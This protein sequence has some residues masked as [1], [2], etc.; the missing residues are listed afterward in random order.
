[1]GNTDIESL[2]LVLEINDTEIQ[3]G[4]YELMMYKP[5]QILQ[6][7]M[8][9]ISLNDGD[10]I[11]IGTPEGLGVVNVGGRFRS[12]IK[13]SDEVLVRKDWVAQ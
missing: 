3:N 9:F 8:R 1:M 7:V 2:S 6:E 12:M 5:Q 13:S 10:I 4:G 11:M